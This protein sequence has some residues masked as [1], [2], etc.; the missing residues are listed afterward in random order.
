MMRFL[1]VIAIL[2]SSPSVDEASAGVP[3]QDELEGDLDF[4]LS[5]DLLEQADFSGADNL[6]NDPEEVNDHE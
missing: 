4:L 1:L 3:V 6:E 2:M 5:M